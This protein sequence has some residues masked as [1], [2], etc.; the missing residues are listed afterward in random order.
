M[1]ESGS[2]QIFDGKVVI[3]SRDRVCMNPDELLASG[4]FFET[5]KQFIELLQKK[6]SK[7]LRIFENQQIGDRDLKLL[8]KTMRFL[9]NLSADLV[10]KV[11][12]GS[13]QFLKD[14]YLFND[15][16]EQ[17][18]N[19]W[20]S[21]HRVMV[22]DSF[23]NNS[24][25]R[26]YRTFN[27][28][29]ETL[30]HVVRSAYRDIQENLTGNHPRV[31]R[32]VSAGVEVGA[33]AAPK[34]IDYPNETYR[35]L[36][37]IPVI[38]QVLIYP[39]MIF[40]SPSNKRSGT[41]ERIDQN[42]LENIE[43]DSKDWLCYPAKVGPLLVMIYFSVSL[44]ELGF[45]LSN[46]FELADDV[47]LERKPDAVYLFGHAAGPQQPG[48]NETVF[49]EDE[50][51]DLLIGAVPLRDQYAYFGYLKK[52]VLTLH[53]I[54]MMHRGRL[55]FH[56]AM[57]NIGLRNQ[58]D[59]TVL[60]VGDTGAGK[61]ETLE[62]LRSIGADLLEDLVIIADDMG[63]L[64]VGEDGRVLGYGT[65]I[66]A[67]VRLDDLQSGYAFGQIDRAII[68]NPDKV[69][70][71]VVL[72]VTRYEEVIRGYPVDIVLYANNYDEVNGHNPVIER[73]RSAEDA[74]DVFRDGAVMSKGTTSTTGLVKS[75]FGNIFGPVQY[76]DV[77]DELAD[78]Y[79]QAM[80]GSH[81][82]VGE[83]RTQLGIHGMEH[84]GPVAAARALLDA[85]K[86]GMPESRPQIESYKE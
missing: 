16:I 9:V 42:P 4:L 40:N 84:E 33:I 14:P 6:D 74:L 37:S 21:L 23:W 11:L 7:L 26:P 39:P 63:S 85:L 28:T 43:I 70:A 47:D 67:F 76:Q 34:E 73:F 48:V 44:F 75:Y 17:L 41:F 36:N 58:A 66:G 83:I 27:D 86:N 50:E 68:M 29:V 46:L 15:F 10:P 18:Y 53:N 13:D 59:K 5:L 30:M 65:E 69:N 60:I 49:F 22:C 54:K 25:Q 79:F 56:G 8:V 80:F 51:N 64:T 55:P 52:M 57:V 71:R 32:Q 31:Y 3:R 62:A 24:D 1:L 38:R 2:Y 61:S 77:H 12:D 78:D 72:P 35:K 82:F 45:S 19:Y 20:R 81:T